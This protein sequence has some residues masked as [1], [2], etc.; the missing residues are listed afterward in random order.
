MAEQNVHSTIIDV[1]SSSVVKSPYN[2][3]MAETGLQ[4]WNSGAYLRCAFSGSDACT[5]NLDQSGVLETVQIRT[6]VD[7]G[8]WSEQIP[9]TPATSQIAVNGITGIGSHTVE[10]MLDSTPQSSNRWTCIENLLRVVSFDVSQGTAQN[11]TPASRRALFYGD[12]I[13]EG[14]FIDGNGGFI[15]SHVQGYCHLAA[16]HLRTADY[17]VG[18]VACGYSG[19]LASVPMGVPFGF[20]PAAPSTDWW[21]M[22]DSDTARV[23]GAIWPDGPPDLIVTEWGTNDAL[24]GISDSALL[25]SVSGFIAAARTAAP[26]SIIVISVPVGQFK[27]NV[28]A[29]AV[30]TANDANTRLLDMG[31]IFGG[32]DVHPTTSQHTNDIAPAFIAA[33]DDAIAA[34]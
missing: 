3:R 15:F 9:V 34:D 19:W 25:G 29:Q 21:D 16:E 12:S 20:N 32:Y 14:I 30:A 1:T 31:A 27:Q 13:W 4:A 28:L 23:S 6:R 22:I 33:L 18:A 10:L 5:V 26:D 7:G 2:W 17:E 24:Q 8:A 11:I